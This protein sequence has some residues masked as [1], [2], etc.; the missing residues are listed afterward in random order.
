MPNTLVDLFQGEQQKNLDFAVLKAL[1]ILK[2][3]PEQ[4]LLL[5]YDII[6]QYSVHLK[7]RIGQDRKSVV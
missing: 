2:I 1:E 4:G 7:E 6:C 3:D 5:I